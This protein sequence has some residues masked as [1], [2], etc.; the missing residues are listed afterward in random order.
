[1]PMRDRP[2]R[3]VPAWDD[4]PD[5]GVPECCLHWSGPRDSYRL[6]HRIGHPDRI[7]IVEMDGKSWVVDEWT[8]EWQRLRPGCL[9][10]VERGGRTVVV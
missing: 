9:V 8:Q 2:V 5:N 4:D 10:V 6:W 7:S 1:M 3:K